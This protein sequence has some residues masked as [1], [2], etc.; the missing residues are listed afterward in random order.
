[1]GMGVPRS[2]FPAR[3]S[4]AGDP[5][6][7]IGVRV[8]LDHR[9]TT[10][11]R[12]VH[13]PRGVRRSHQSDHAGHRRSQHLD[14]RTSADGGDVRHFGRVG[15]RAHR[16]WSRRLLGSAGMETGDRPAQ[17]D[18][19][20][21]R[22]H[23]RDAAPLRP[24]GGRHPR[25]RPATGARPHPRPRSWRAEATDRRSHLPRAQPGRR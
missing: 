7:G 21:P 25:N 13:D 11:P 2:A 10:G 19:P 22:V 16:R 20:S 8:G 14:A 23:R 5:P 1:M 9:D 4:I 6:R 18:E 3:P 15:P 24:G 17:A 12:C